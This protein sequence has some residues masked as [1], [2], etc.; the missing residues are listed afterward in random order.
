MSEKALVRIRFLFQFGQIE[1]HRD[2][3][4]HRRIL[5]P[6]DGRDAI[7]IEIDDKRRQRTEIVGGRIVGKGQRKRDDRQLRQHGFWGGCPAVSQ[8]FR[9]QEFRPDN[10]SKIFKAELTGLL[11]KEPIEHFCERGLAAVVAA[12]NNRRA[13]FHGDLYIVQKTETLN[14]HICKSDHAAP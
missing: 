4:E 14:A 6:G 11:A 5:D 8:P 7:R 9:G 13:S 2:G 12:D 10:G 3:V 1:Q